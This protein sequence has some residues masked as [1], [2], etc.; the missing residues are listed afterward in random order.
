MYWTLAQMVTHQ[1]SNGCNLRTGDLLA[2]GT[3]SGGEHGTEGCLLEMTQ[4]GTRRIE[5][6]S[7]ETRA[8]LE[9]GDEVIMRAFCERAG[10]A[11]IGFGDC[12]GTVMPARTAVS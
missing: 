6:P 8:F 2:S 4:Q 7:D 10:Y 12:A 1:T 11:R 3:I 5:L 9:D